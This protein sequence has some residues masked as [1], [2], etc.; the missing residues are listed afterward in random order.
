MSTIYTVIKAVKN[1]FPMSLLIHSYKEYRTMSLH[2]IE[3][4]MEEGGHG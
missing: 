4:S 3:G 2:L 1:Y